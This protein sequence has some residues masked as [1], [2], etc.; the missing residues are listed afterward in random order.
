MTTAEPLSA[1]LKTMSLLLQSY[2]SA[3][4]SLGDKL[5]LWLVLKLGLWSN[6]CSLHTIMASR[7]GGPAGHLHLD[8]DLK[9][10]CLKGLE[11]PIGSNGVSMG[12]AMKEVDVSFADSLLSKKEIWRIL[13]WRRSMSCLNWPGL[14]AGGVGQNLSPRCNTCVWNSFNLNELRL[15]TL[16]SMLS[17]S[18]IESCN[19][20][21]MVA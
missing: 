8:L 13:L 9:A 4:D 21:T 15:T 16:L 11:V 18:M 1:G 3:C 14:G 6:C 12:A 7:F 2:F 17:F 19:D 5:F 10:L 20:G